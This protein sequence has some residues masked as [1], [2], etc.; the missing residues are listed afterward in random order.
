AEGVLAQDRRPIDLDDVVFDEAKRLRSTTGLQ[1]DTAGVS[2]GRIDADP[3]AIRRLLRNLTDN[4]ARHAH[5]TVALHLVQR[6]GQVVLDVDDDGPGIAAQDRARV[7]DRFIRLDDARARDAGGAGLG[8]AIAA[9]L[10]TAHGGEI[11][12][13]ASPIGGTRVTLRFPAPDNA[14]DSTAS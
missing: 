14:P 3:A 2:G 13:D 11:A 1:V 5:A 7:L 6:N 12:I 8:L 9:E 10:V 4:A